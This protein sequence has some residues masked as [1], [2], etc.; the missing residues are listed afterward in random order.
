MAQ[1]SIPEKAH[2]LLRLYALKHGL[3]LYE[4]LDKIIV[5]AASGLYVAKETNGGGKAGE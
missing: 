4:A 5:K 1:V 2:E 3:K